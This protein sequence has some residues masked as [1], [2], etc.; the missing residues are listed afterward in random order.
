MITLSL[1]LC[2]FLYLYYI[3]RTKMWIPLA[4]WGPFFW[5]WGHSGCFSRLQKTEGQNLIWRLRLDEGLGQ[6]QGLNCE[7]MYRCMW[8]RVCTLRAI[9]LPLYVQN[10]VCH[11]YNFYE[12]LEM[13]Q[14]LLFIACYDINSCKLFDIT[15]D[16]GNPNKTRSIIHR[17]NPSNWKDARIYGC[18]ILSSTKRVQL[19]TNI[20]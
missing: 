20:I 14:Y 4:K 6:G 17:T 19:S 11:L 15:L 5:K 1:Q 9:L 2:V 7:L 16:I 8:A 13:I 12:T 10:A 18:Y 3:L